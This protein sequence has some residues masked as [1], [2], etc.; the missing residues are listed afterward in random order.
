MSKK[1][2]L[3][4]EIPISKKTINKFKNYER[5]HTKAD[6]ETVTRHSK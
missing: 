2:I 5:N 1:S 3:K 6:S 4:P